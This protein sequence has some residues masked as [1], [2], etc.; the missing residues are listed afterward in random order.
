MRS[1]VSSINSFL[2]LHKHVLPPYTQTHTST[3]N[4]TL[5]TEKNHTPKMAS[6]DADSSAF[7]HMSSLLRASSAQPYQ[8]PSPP[9]STMDGSCSPAPAAFIC[10]QDVHKSEPSDA[11]SEYD[12]SNTSYADPSPVED[13]SEPARK[14]RK[15][16]GQVL[17]KPTTNL[18]PR[19]RAKTE[20]EK[21]QRKYERVQ[22]N[23]HAA[24]MSRMR[25]Q[26]EMET[27]KIVNDRLLQD[28][29]ALEDEVTRLRDELNR[30]RS[31]NTS[32]TT[33]FSRRPIT[34]PYKAENANNNNA[35]SHNSPMP[36]LTSHSPSDQSVD[37]DILTTPHPTESYLTPKF[38]LFVD[39]SHSKQ[40]GV[41][42]SAEMC[43]PQWTPGLFASMISTP[44]RL[45][46]EPE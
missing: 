44:V 1:P 34:P 9:S 35:T 4:P 24:H 40:P 16:W 36:S 10:P 39:T 20:E 17:P 8:G 25:K 23:R 3:E 15:S 11:A 46:M 31:G 5:S 6:L 12:N 29:S 30:Y 27:L 33:N 14:K 45:K 43:S 22:R 21:A 13:G 28:N 41:S 19:K 38:P 37:M 32:L 18:P 26:D 42:H 2:L 7:S